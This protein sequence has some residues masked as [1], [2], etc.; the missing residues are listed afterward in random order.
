[1]PSSVIR[2][3]C[4]LG[5]QR[6]LR[7]YYRTGTVYDYIDVPEEVYLAMRKAFS[8]GTYLNQFIKGKYAFRKVT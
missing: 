4:Y 3:F 6:L 2:H 8:K 1:M 7:I 5:E